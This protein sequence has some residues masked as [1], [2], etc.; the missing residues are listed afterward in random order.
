VLPLGLHELDGGA[1]TDL[2]WLD[3]VY[4]L[5]EIATEPN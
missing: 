2:C 3:F 1:A 4:R 5:G